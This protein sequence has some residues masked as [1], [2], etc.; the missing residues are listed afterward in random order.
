[1]LCHEPWRH[2]RRGRSP[3]AEVGHA[4]SRNVGTV[5][6]V[7]SMVAE[8]SHE[9]VTTRLSDDVDDAPEAWPNSA[10]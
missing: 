4:V 5:E 8:A 1:M 3:S 6:R 10:L 9:F 2:H 7:V